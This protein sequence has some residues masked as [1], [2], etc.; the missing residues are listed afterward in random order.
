MIGEGKFRTDLSEAFKLLQKLNLAVYRNY[1]PT[2]DK[3][4]T[5]L[6][7]G[8]ADYVELY[9]RYLTCQAHDFLLDD[10]SFFLLSQESSRQH[11]FVIRLFRISL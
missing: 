3:A 11:C 6:L 9:N 5:E 4:T 2:V 7:R 1:F 8:S 10:G